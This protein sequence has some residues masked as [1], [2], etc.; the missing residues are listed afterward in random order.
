[1]VKLLIRN[2][3]I[4]STNV[5]H[6]DTMRV[7]GLAQR[8]RISR[9]TLDSLKISNEL[10]NGL[11]LNELGKILNQLLIFGNIGLF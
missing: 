11:L 6:V 2:G 4:D 10:R 3:L 5:S 7:E 8:F 1:V 9:Y